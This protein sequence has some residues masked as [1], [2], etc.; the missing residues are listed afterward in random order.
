MLAVL[1]HHVVQRHNILFI[2]HPR[3]HVWVVL[4]EHAAAHIRDLVEVNSH[5]GASSPRTISSS[6]HVMYLCII[7]PCVHSLMTLH[8][9]V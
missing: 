1:K 9:E 6:T 8:V 2:H 4:Q 5:Y 3:K 7:T